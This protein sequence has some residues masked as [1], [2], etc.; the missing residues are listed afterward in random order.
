MQKMVMSIATFLRNAKS[1]FTDLKSHPSKL[2]FVIGNQSGDLDSIIS[3]ISY[4]YLSYIAEYTSLPSNHVPPRI[5]TIPV[6]N[7]KSSELEL[8]KDVEYLFSDLKVEKQDLCF[9]NELKFNAEEKQNLELVLVDHNSIESNIRNQLYYKD[10][11]IV[12]IIDHHKDENQY[13]DAQP[14]IIEVVGSCSTMIAKHW[15]EKLGIMDNKFQINRSS[16]N[17][18]GKNFD[19]QELAKLLLGPLL[20]DTS[21]LQYKTTPDDIGI[22]KAYREISTG[23]NTT[24]YFDILKKEKDNIDTL[25]AVDIINKDY[26]AYQFVNPELNSEVQLLAGEDIIIGITSIVKP[27]GWLLSRD[28]LLEM[29]KSIDEFGKANNVNVLILMTNFNDATHGFCRELAIKP[30]IDATGPA[31]QA[32][33]KLSQFLKRK[34]LTSDLELQLKSSSNREG[35]LQVYSQHNLKASRKQVAPILRTL[36]T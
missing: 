24:E 11:N 33:V 1:A 23:L 18:V 12:S 19:L 8:R 15:F 22:F 32:N 21:N 36:L 28:G 2:K 27:M 9:I 10:G 14:R 26:K 35:G 13:L 29:E 6:L 7:F 3:S 20:I 17:E 4:A 16:A 31:T 5:N 34:L 25:K 30:I